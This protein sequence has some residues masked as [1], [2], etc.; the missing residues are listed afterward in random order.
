MSQRSKIPRPT[1][2]RLSLYLRELERLAEQRQETISS[3][4]LGTALGLTDAQVRKDLACFGQFGH[5]GIG[6]R[7]PDLIEQ[8]RKI[9][10]TDRNWNAAVVGA[11]KIGRAVMAY[12][13]FQRKGFEVVAVFDDD[14]K[15]VGT[16][17]A[18]HHVRPMGDLAALVKERDIKIGIVAVPREVAQEV[19]DELIEAGVLGIL[20]FA[21]IRL[22]V[23][24]AV[25]VVSVDFSVS[26]EQLAFQ[27]SLGLTGDLEQGVGSRE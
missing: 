18:D 24:D 7:V 11:G 16:V 17:V 4:V 1:V 2:K 22:D 10:G 19:A 5:P 8:L 21:P 13:Q 15:V 20:N 25:S 9:L 12:Q 6:Y 3:K 14:A 27:I 26:L 23:H